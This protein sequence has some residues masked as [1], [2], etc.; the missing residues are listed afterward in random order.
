MRRTQFTLMFRSWNCTYRCLFVAC[1]C[2]V[3]TCWTPTNTWYQFSI[4]AFN[5]TQALTHTHPWTPWAPRWPTNCLEVKPLET[6]RMNSPIQKIDREIQHHTT[7]YTDTDWPGGTWEVYSMAMF[8]GTMLT[9]LQIHSTYTYILGICLFVWFKHSLKAKYE[10]FLSTS[11]KK[12][13]KSCL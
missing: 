5:N 11:Q 6:L 2:C 10:L 7:G 9:T 8:T 12:T 1:L 4:Q 13:A 3:F